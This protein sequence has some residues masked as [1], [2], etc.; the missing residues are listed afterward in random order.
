MRT[1]LR[2]HPELVLVSIWPVL[3]EA[4]AVLFHHVHKQAELDL[5]AWVDAGAV[6][7]L[8]LKPGA[9]T[10]IRQRMARYRDLPLDFADASLAELLEQERLDTVLSLDTDFDIYRGPSRRRFKNPLSL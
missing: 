2:D 7:I 6:G 4:C 10:R 1:F 8:E 9:L 5:L 3:A